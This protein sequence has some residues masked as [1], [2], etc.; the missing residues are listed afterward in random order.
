MS[1]SSFPGDMG[2][3]LENTVKLTAG[4][5]HE[6][7]LPE[8]LLYE[9]LKCDQIIIL[10]NRLNAD[11]EYVRQSLWN[12]LENDV[13]A[14]RHNAEPIMSISLNRILSAPASQKIAEPVERFLR[15]LDEKQSDAY[16]FIR[17]SGISKTEAESEINNNHSYYQPTDVIEEEEEEVDSASQL[18][19]NLV[20]SVNDFLRSLNSPTGKYIIEANVVPDTGDSANDETRS[21]Y[22]TGNNKS[23]DESK[24]KG[25]GLPFLH[26]YSV[27]LVEMAKKGK[28]DPIIGRKN[29]LTRVMQVLCRR[30]KNNPVLVGESGVGK[31]AIIEGLASRIATGDVPEKLLDCSIWALD[32]GSLIAG[33]QF[34]GDFEERLKNVIEEL[35]RTPR[36]I[37]FV[38]E[39]HVVVGAGAVS[40]SALDA[41]NILKPALNSG[42]IKCIGITTY[43][44]YKNHILKDKAFSRRFQKVDIPESSESDTLAILRGLLDCYQKHYDVKY[45][46]SAVS[47]AVK[48]SARHL[49]ERFLPDKAIDVIDEAGARNS[50]RG[51]TAKKL[52]TATDIGE[53]VALMAN[54]PSTKLTSSDNTLMEDLE[55]QLNGVIFG[56]ND[57]IRQVTA[58]IKIAKAGIGN[59]L[60]PIGVFLCCGPTGCGK[61]E[62]ARQL[63]EKLAINFTR[64]DMSEYSEK[65][66]VSKLIGSPPG[67]VGFEQSG[68][69]TE[70]LLR[71]PHSVVLLDEIEKA[72]PDVF[73]IFLQIMDYGTL[74]DNNGRK[75]DFRNA[76]ILMTSNVGAKNLDANIIGFSNNTATSDST[77]KEVEKFFSP[78]F[79]NR[80]DAI[81]YFNRLSLPLMKQIVNKFIRQLAAEL[82]SKNVTVTL[83][84]EAEEWFALNGYDPK[85]GARPLERLIKQ[86]IQEKL[87][88]AILFGNLKSGGTAKVTCK[89]NTI[90]VVTRPKE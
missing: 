29:E 42:E 18:G 28:I 22:N 69:L 55:E 37:L 10:F 13:E 63:A 45:S 73:N 17:K 86:Q 41:S 39:I 15:I 57:A 78:E 16:F 43:D 87:A 67:Y 61:T 72:H 80:L 21:E 74:S 19:N 60:K 51:G 62:L 14:I 53:I 70:A 68:L 54:I 2:D 8:H 65:H 47:A 3:I 46:D 34:R 71:Q 64:F 48:L 33:T 11:I 12:F 79:R 89:D 85:M 36:A 6:M 1:E 40:S 30:K 76:I 88:D 9:L 31:T 75:A 24:K 90:S 82:K 56:Q 58:T 27:N 84:K 52:I 26:K 50:L 81:I 77:R 32:I 25:D 49:Q 20:E 35:K 7:V 44:D 23:P 66:T 5:H 4:F 83:T 38:D 59:K